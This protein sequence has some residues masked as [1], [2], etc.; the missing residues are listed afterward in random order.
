MTSTTTPAELIARL[1]RSGVQLWEQ[2]GTLR[3]RAPKGSLGPEQLQELKDGKTRIL[4]LLRSEAQPQE[5]TPDPAGRHAPFPLTDVQSAYLLGRNEAFGYGGVAC[6]VYLEITYPDLDPERTEDA[7]NRL[8]ERHDMLRAVIDP[9]GHQSV[10][11]TVPRLS[12]PVEDMRGAGTERLEN[13]LKQAREDMGHRVYDSSHWPLFDLR[14]TRTDTRAVLHLSMDFLIADWASIWLLL[15]E[16][17][18][19]HSDPGTRLQP[20]QVRFRD[21]L[22]AERGLQETAAY[23]RDKQYWLA[24]LD[25]LPLA[26]DLPVVDD[27]AVAPRFRRRFLKLDTAAWEQ[28]KDRAQ[29]RG[30]TPSSVVLAAYAA[31]IGRW[32]RTRDFCLNLTVL[33]RLPLHP[34]IGRIVGDFTSI[35]LLAV[36][37]GGDSTFTERAQAVAGQLFE[38]LDHRLYSGVEVLRELARHRGREAALM[39]VVFTSA[40]GLADAATESRASGRLDGYGITQTPQV[41][42]DCQAMD[43]AEGLQVNWDVREGVFP[44]GLV[45]D[46]FDAFE[47]LLRHLADGEEPW[48]AQDAIALPRWQAEERRRANDTSAPL[49][50]ALLHHGVF[51]QALRTPDRPALITPDGTLTYAELAARA[52]GVARE[53]RSA[54]CASGER[55]AV[56][57]DKGAEQ[58][59]AVLGALLAGCVYLPV[60][61]VQP[62][63]RRTAM[64]TDAGVRH[65]LTQ[66][67]VNAGLRE[68]NYRVVAVDS[69]EPVSTDEAYDDIERDPDE[70]AY[71]IYTSGS[72]GRPKG[73]VISHRAAL[74]TLVDIGRRFEIGADDRVLGLA[75][76]GFDLSVFD[77]FGPLSTGGALVLPDPARSTDPSHWAQL[78]AEHGV[79]VWNSVPALMQ[80]LATYLDGEKDVGLP[81]LRLA[82]LSGDWIPVPLPGAITR[83]LPG[84]NVV[85][86][87][88][89]TEA[90]IWSIHHPCVPADAGRPS[91]PYGLPLANQGFRVL[92]T[93][94]RDCPVWVTGELYISGDGLAQGYL[95]DE[96]TTAHRFIA[97]PRDGQRL[98]RTGDMG[99]YLPGGEIEFLGRE[100]TQVKVRGHRIELGEIEAALCDHPAVATACVVADGT[101]TER[102][103]LG[104]VET[105]ATDEPGEGATALGPSVSKA[106]D[107][108]L[109]AVGQAETAAH[110]AS[111]D[112]AVLTSMAGALAT[113]GLP[114]QAGE[115][116]EARLREAGVASR[117][118]WLV[119]RWAAVLS[120][121]GISHADDGTV[122]RR[123]SDA[124]AAWREEIAS[125]DVLAYVREHAS[126]L[127]ELLR[128]T[129]DPV[130]LLFPDGSFD[131]AHALYRHNA[132]AR[133]LNQAVASAL[134]RIAS[135]HPEDRPLRVLE[136]GAGTGGTTEDALA[137][138]AG[139]DTDYLFTDVAPFFLPEA[140]SRFGHHASVRFGV[141]DIDE[142]YRDQGLAPN[143][144]DVVLAA[145]VLENARD[146]DA[147]LAR[148]T[149]LVAPGGW[150]LL[151]EPTREH[152][153]ILASQAFMMTEP[154]DGRAH[155]GPS[156]LDRE[157]WLERLAKSG[158]EEVLCL[159]G[160]G[161]VLGDQ[162]LHLFAARVKTSRAGATEAELT[163]FVRERLPAHMIPSHIQIADALPL[164]RNGKV[165]RTTLR[166]W[167]PATPAEEQQHLTDE[168]PVGALEA[169]L[170]ELWAA[171]LPSG[172]IGRTDDFY[173]H[174]A[175]SLIMARMAGRIREEIPEAADVPFDTMLRHLLNRPTVAELAQFLDADDSTAAQPALRRA[176]TGNAAL[177]PF[178]TSGEGPLRV[179]FHAGLG[180][181]DCYRPLAGRLVE[182]DLGPV[183][184]IVIDDTERYCSLDPATVVERAADDYAER[185]L[186]EGH[187]RVQL[188]GYCLGGLYATEVARR[189][190][191]RGVTVDDLVLISSH[192]VVI[193][194][195][196]DLMIEI[197]F[198]PNLH[199]SFAQT[200]L[201]DL[202]GDTLV[203]GFMHVIDRNDGKVPQGALDAVGGDAQLDEAGAFFR[204]LRSFT[205]EERFEVYARTASRESGEAVP[206]DMVTAL[207]KVFRQS[208][209][210]ARFTPPPYAGDIRFL[211]PRGASGFAPGMDETTLAFWRD[212]CI[213]NLPVTDVEGN[214]FSCIEEP[215]AGR[216]AELVAAPL[217]PSPKR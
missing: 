42:I 139:R 135:E 131:T 199:I 93:A 23:Q 169:R 121:A 119:R 137:S 144:F 165:D 14:V 184:G 158:A 35:N 17:E 186:A 10:L 202:D 145:G 87:G 178:S 170:A 138:L 3:Y 166:H 210:S 98:Y 191:E 44:D 62:V 134:S 91:V 64:L 38:D 37:E 197:L 108:T 70:P 110:I 148:L 68:E 40:I 71:V 8:V 156:Y 94:L 112:T 187:G 20:L 168:A 88:G 18:A 205:R 150:L 206:A 174:G 154:Q 195:E 113:M 147:A 24:R 9:A 179:M 79:S 11:P 51:A 116:S 21:Y 115:I 19:L 46:M 95:G 4:D 102:G 183:L 172:R 209:L 153:W 12:V 130:Q 152:P 49:P 50:D 140:R 34:D 85:S 185:I 201:G 56:V 214:H 7:W 25:T 177:M 215:N 141:F 54:G 107:A 53:L 72:T 212:V 60:D 59:V 22:L 211:R 207:F 33:N 32:S 176:T 159:P 13:S 171:A 157:Q 76:L 96:E 114:A 182:Q 190:E 161:H 101:G 92:D 118:H 67:W 57:M 105:T 163:A 149:E 90:S 28:L 89:A 126:R 82:L 143:S 97:H 100:D 213:G 80:M 65:V 83:R 208:F 120:E 106:A 128:G 181:M 117:H 122:E 45:D 124:E 30:V 74:N 133:Y 136:A 104:V 58:V 47:R 29:R 162:H 129:K 200:G 192:P 43:D 103:L 2:D 31:V 66:S 125:R 39:P 146:I 61:T 123:W 217:L 204:H 78:I 164:T 36:E 127:P 142:G 194:V 5:L 189:L 84:L 111:F 75:N 203:R 6:H 52:R 41:F 173:D 99:R 73:V 109:P 86:L 160:H 198:L 132:A 48:D 188:I 216:V 167:R 81:T 77:V 196:D 15:A 155:D 16:F 69:V 55:V 63:R 27:D 1:R 180:T 175:D 26:P 193:D 151:T